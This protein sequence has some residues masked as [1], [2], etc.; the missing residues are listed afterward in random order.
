MSLILSVSCSCSWELWGYMIWDIWGTNWVS[1]VEIFNF[2]K[3]SN[4][5][6][7]IWETEMDTGE[8]RVLVHISCLSLLICY[9]YLPALFYISDLSLYYICTHWIGSPKSYAHNLSRSELKKVKTQLRKGQ[10]KIVS[11]PW[12]SCAIPHIANFFPK[13]T[14]EGTMW[15]SDI[16]GLSSSREGGSSREMDIPATHPWES[17]P[18]FSNWFLLRT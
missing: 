15:G 6:W 12:S 2:L 18:S 9:S 1:C 8:T 10:L 17:H 3:A 14:Q 7:L 16:L 11:L 4:V 13:R 5:C